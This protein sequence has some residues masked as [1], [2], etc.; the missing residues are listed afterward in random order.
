MYA[1]WVGSLFIFCMITDKGSKLLS[2]TLLGLLHTYELA[3]YNVC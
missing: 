2:G 3:S 1:P